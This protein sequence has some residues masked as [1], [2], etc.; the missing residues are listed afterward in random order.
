VETNLILG[1]Q[2]DGLELAMCNCAQC[3]EYRAALREL[4]QVLRFLDPRPNNPDRPERHPELTRVEEDGSIIVPL[5]ITHARLGRDAKLFSAGWQ[6]AVARLT[7]LADTRSVCIN[8]TNSPQGQTIE[9]MAAGL[10]NV[11]R[12]VCPVI[13]ASYAWVDRST[14]RIHPR[15]I[16]SFKEIKHWFFANIFGPQL[17]ASAPRGFI[18]EFPAYE[19]TT[20][21]DGSV[22]LTSAATYAEWYFSPPKALADYL[23]E[24]AP[25]IRLFRK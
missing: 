1:K 19:R 5:D 23:S 25:K 14:E 9:E 13:G 11:A 10:I 6:L 4:A 7:Y 24:R 20:L 2:I 22:L 17:A 16:S 8:Q 18:E 21:P 3:P 15:K 12:D